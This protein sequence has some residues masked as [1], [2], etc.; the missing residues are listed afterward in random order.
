[1]GESGGKNNFFSFYIAIYNIL[2]ID[3]VINKV[4]VREGREAGTIHRWF[5]GV[6]IE[7]GLLAINVCV[8]CRLRG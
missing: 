8:V 7:L 1:M 4:E 3:R 5:T 2:N 6:A